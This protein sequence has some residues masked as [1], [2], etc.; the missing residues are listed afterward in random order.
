MFAYL[1]TQLHEADC[2]RHTLKCKVKKS[3]LQLQAKTI[4]TTFRQ[5]N[6]TGI[7]NSE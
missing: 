4:S 1:Q 5:L 3:G 2:K 7:L 6:K